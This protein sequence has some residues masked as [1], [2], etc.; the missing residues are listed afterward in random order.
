MRGYYCNNKATIFVPESVLFTCAVANSQVSAWYATQTFATK[1]GGFFDFEPRYSTQLV[2]PAATSEQQNVVE[3]VAKYV[4]D[5][6]S[7]HTVAGF[8]E[9]LL[10]G[11]MYELFFPEDL[12]TLGLRFFDLLAIE[13]LPKSSD[14][15]G[16]EAFHKKISDVNH[17]LYA[18]LF[19]LNGLE[20]V[21]IIE[22]R[23]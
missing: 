8:F 14:Q 21:R 2:I 12:H 18:A 16:W 13:G 6:Q 20:V 9:R 22:G 19:A 23:E 1:Q 15:S 17:S 7:N 3:R 10:N 5:H 11:L 4:I